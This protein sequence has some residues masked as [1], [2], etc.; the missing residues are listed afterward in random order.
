MPCLLE[1]ILS[2]RATYTRLRRY[3]D[4]EQAQAQG[5]AFKNKTE[6]EKEEQVEAARLWLEDAYEEFEQVSLVWKH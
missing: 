5:Q 6:K 2:S 3:V 1:P 4:P